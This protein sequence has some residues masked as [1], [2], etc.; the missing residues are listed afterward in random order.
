[1]DGYPILK[2]KDHFY[3][4][5]FG[6]SFGQQGQRQ[7]ISRNDHDIIEED[8]E[9]VGL[10]SEVLEIGDGLQEEQMDNEIKEPSLNKHDPVNHVYASHPKRGIH[11]IMF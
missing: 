8:S 3:L 9:S 1:M 4:A 6:C 11:S 5:D 2:V 10:G 7:R